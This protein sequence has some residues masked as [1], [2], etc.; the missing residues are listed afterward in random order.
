MIVLNHQTVAAQHGNP[1]FV[2]GAI[3]QARVPPDYRAQIGPIVVRDVAGVVPVE[4][5]PEAALLDLIIQ[6]LMVQCHRRALEAPT[7]IR[8]VHPGIEDVT[9]PGSRAAKLIVGQNEIV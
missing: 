7:G 5:A 1:K 3:Q 9:K 4:A 8:R 2:P 6:K